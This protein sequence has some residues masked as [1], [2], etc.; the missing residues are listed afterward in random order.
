M[1]FARFALVRVRD[2][3]ICINLITAGIDLAQ[4]AARIGVLYECHVRQHDWLSYG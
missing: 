2:A 1:G 3:E 4:P